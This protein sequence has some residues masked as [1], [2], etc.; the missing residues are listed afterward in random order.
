MEG[1][2][3]GAVLGAKQKGEAP[4]RTLQV[5]RKE[6][7]VDSCQCEREQR[8]QRGQ[9]GRGQRGPETGNYISSHL[10]ARSKGVSLGF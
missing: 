4:K 5:R 2:N 1:W 9:R 3:L 6:G 10:G 7:V 8:G